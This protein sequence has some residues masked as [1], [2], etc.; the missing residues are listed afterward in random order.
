MTKFKRGDKL[1]VVDAGYATSIR[2]GDIVYA[3]RDSGNNYTVVG[4]ES[5]NDKSVCCSRLCRT[6]DDAGWWTHRFELYKEPV[7]KCIID[8]KELV[9]T[10]IY[11]RGKLTEDQLTRI[12]LIA[13]E[14]A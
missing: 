2:K 4:K 9:H 7:K 3:L 10:T 13:S 6:V 12:D 5:G 1:V 8:V 11:I 14:G